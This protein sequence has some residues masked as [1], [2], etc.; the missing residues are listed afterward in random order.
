MVD[1]AK[2]GIFVQNAPYPAWLATGNGDCVYGNPALEHL[3]GLNS[4]EIVPAD[5]RSFLLDDDRVAAT[6]S[7]QRSLTT[8]IP[9]RVRVRLRGIDGVTRT[10]EL[11]AFGYKGDDGTERWLFIG[12]DVAVVAHQGP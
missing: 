7:W 5:W 11:I 2:V 12:S 8:G 3:T 10:V 4:D 6:A 9:Y 1:I